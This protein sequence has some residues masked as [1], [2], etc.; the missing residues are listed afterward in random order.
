MEKISV[1][2]NSYNQDKFFEEAITSVLTQS[3]QN[4]KLIISENGSTDNSKH[5]L[6]KYIHHKKIKILN[7]TENESVSKRF[8][9]AL[10][11]CKGEFISF[12]Y[13]DDIISK[14]KF[15]IQIEEFQKLDDDYGVVYGNMEIFN[16]YTN[17]RFIRSVIKSD[18]WCLKQ[19]LENNLLKGHID[20]VSP[21]S[22]RK[23][24]NTYQFL[25]NIFAE[26][27]GIFLRIALSYKFKYLPHT[28]AYFRDTKFNN[29]KATIKNLS[30]HLE[31]L[32]KLQQDKIFEEK[33]YFFL[34]NNYKFNFQQNIAWGNLRANGDSKNSKKIFFNIL[35]PENLK[36]FNFRTFYTFV[37]LC[38][39]NFILKILNTIL[40]KILNVKTNNVS[41]ES[42]GGND[43]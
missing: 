6:N 15:K 21:L 18:G 37:L 22:R 20:M 43:K 12:L 30:F 40:N 42:Y 26:G 16:Q 11:E 39:P 23:C 13:S 35:K 2:L 14:D 29:G 34:M 41:R 28:F 4:F 36:F 27:E 33:D 38:F 7:Y 24:F 9:Q 32:K 3:Y 10:R 1:I 5:I 8:N 25:E 31:T 17:K 19:Q